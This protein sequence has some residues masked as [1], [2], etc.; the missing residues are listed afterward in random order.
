[1]FVLDLLLVGLSAGLFYTSVHA[2]FVQKPFEL[3]ISN[4]RQASRTKDILNSDVDAFIEGLLRSWNSPGGIS[5]A[6]VRQSDDGE[7][8]VEVKGYGF[9]RVDGKKMS[10]HSLVGIASN[11]KLFTALGTGLLISNE[12]LSLSW[13][14]KIADVVPE[15]GL[16]DSIASAETTIVDAMS[17]RTGLPR[18]DLM[19]SRTDNTSSI[20]QR[21]RYLRTSAPFRTIWQYCN[22]MYTLLS[23]LPTLLV[24]KP[25][26]RYIKDNIFVPLNLSSTTYSLD[27]ARASGHLADPICR[28]G[29]NRS[30]DVFG[31]GKARAALY[32]NWWLDS[33][34]DGNYKSGAGG[35]IMNAKDA[36]KWLQ[37][38]LLEGKNPDTGEQVIPAQVIQRLAAGITVSVPQAAY[39]ELSPIVYG[40]GQSRG[41][42]RG[43]EYIEHG[44]S[45]TGYRTQITRFPWAKLGVAV[46]SNDDTYGSVFH[47]IIKWR[48]VDEALELEPIDWDSRQKS[49]V[50][51]AYATYETSALPRPSK[52]ALPSRPFTSLAGVYHNTGYG[53]MEL[54]L[55]DF[56]GSGESFHQSDSCN[57]L[58]EEQSIILPGAVGEGIPTLIAHWNKS[59]SSH[60]RLE[61]FD[62]ELFNLTALDSRPTLNE[63]DPYWT[64]NFHDLEIVTAEFTF[65][66]EVGFG[67]TGGF[68]GAGVNVAGPVGN[69]VKEKAEVWF[70]RSNFRRK[71]LS[72]RQAPLKISMSNIQPATEN[73]RQRVLPYSSEAIIKEGPFTRSLSIVDA[74]VLRY[75]PTCATWIFDPT[76]SY[77]LD[78]LFL[79]LSKTL[80]SYP[81]WCGSLHMPRN[82][83][84]PSAAASHA[85]RFNRPLVTW[86]TPADLGVEFIKAESPHKLAKLIPS[87]EERATAH[88]IWD[89]NVIP[90]LGIFPQ[91]PNLALYD[92]VS[93][94]GLPCMIIQVT[95]FACGGLAI[96]V[97]LAHVL[98]DAQTLLT[99]VHDWA[100]QNRRL[101]EGMK[102]EDVKV[103][104][105][106]FQPEL[107]D[108]AAE[109]D[110][111]AA[112]PD[113][114]VIAKARSIP[115]HRH[116]WWASSTED[117]PP[118]MLK[119]TEIPEAFR[120]SVPSLTLGKPLPWSQWDMLAPVSHY[121]IHF[122]RDEV[123]AMWDAS[124]AAI[125]Q[126]ASPAPKIS[127]LDALFAHMW[128]LIVKARGI[129]NEDFPVHLDTTIGLRPRLSP[130]LPADF[131]GS[132]I[133]N[134]PV[135]LP[136]S[137]V[138]P[139][140]AAAVRQSMGRYDASTLGVLLHEMAHEVDPSRIWNTFLGERHTIATSWLESRPGLGAYDVDYGFGKPRMVESMMPDCDGC[141][142]V[143]ESG[144]PN[145]RSQPATFIPWYQNG[146]VV[147][148]HLRTDV[149]QRL[150][151][152][153]YLRKY[154]RKD[155]SLQLG[156]EPDL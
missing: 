99:F 74:T 135:T 12:S 39:P 145:A 24:D 1:M 29:V 106:P 79:S 45:T 37:V 75:T 130:A 148:L 23:Y 35:V 113:G 3:H 83:D 70:G 88:R 5:V 15:W 20:L 43:H 119:S 53:D 44:G 16:A 77:S 139:G 136:A 123:L 32:P 107:V 27:V 121:L 109:G 150:L 57:S 111:D 153:P 47:E 14:T 156:N 116:D 100:T 104:K 18:H 143:M 146:V 76:H 115:L 141:V 4:Q 65:D 80:D 105:R 102:V 142:Q 134:I 71:P 120:N 46:F 51:E 66:G 91:T 64:Y 114:A 54:C 38:L 140:A 89:G 42:Y 129:D 93:H 59:W 55:F 149:M 48:L 84:S 81:Q 98:A 92:R 62:G 8:D 56:E 17:H 155:R 95:T 73:Y 126:K 138:G 7:W 63:S 118:F 36:A 72:R 122:S 94:E 131:L 108:A 82:N 10:E 9:A 87:C 96:T 49:A 34:E 97:K 50:R 28:D 41:T 61:H 127:K 52:P 144:I 133:M 67:I 147:S 22:N 125:S 154:D 58:I 124:V 40:G 11:S 151:A 13:N 26:A 19:Y 2:Q 117:C 60:L 6:V 86:G 33:S 31:M 68:W 30:D 101:L 137:E 112:T 132:P 103:I 110:I 152:D 21:L 90:L 128:T 85:E 69:S 78:T 25:F